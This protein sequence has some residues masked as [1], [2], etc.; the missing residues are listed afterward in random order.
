MQQQIVDDFPMQIPTIV[1]RGSYAFSLPSNSNCV[2]FFFLSFFRSLLAPY[3]YSAPFCMAGWRRKS[4]H[5]EA[6]FHLPFSIVLFFWL[7]FDFLLFFFFYP[8]PISPEPAES[9]SHHSSPLYHWSRL[10]L[11]HFVPP[12]SYSKSLGSQSLFDDLIDLM[13]STIDYYY[14]FSFLFLPSH[15]SRFSH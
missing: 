15:F 5:V 3:F 11:R 4:R 13:F 9:S 12:S 6:S 1:E 2:F 14:S 7:P 10:L 8:A